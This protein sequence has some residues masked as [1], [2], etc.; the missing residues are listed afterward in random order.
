MKT[1]QYRYEANR[2]IE[3]VQMKVVWMLPRWVIQWA[4]V[5]CFAHGTTGRWSHTIAPT[6][7][8]DEALKRWDKPNDRKGK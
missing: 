7:T 3:K 8:V 6:L 2:L 1:W 4:V 5:R